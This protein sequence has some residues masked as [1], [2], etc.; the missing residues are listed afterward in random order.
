MIIEAVSSID[1]SVLAATDS[2]FN[3]EGVRQVALQ[4]VGVGLA[5]VAIIMLFG[6]SRSG[7]G[8]ALGKLA[9]AVIALVIAG[10]SIGLIS[11]RSGD[12]VGW[13]LN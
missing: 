6:I 5:V 10:L 7:I 4:I 13:L 3:V 8:D 1:M 12:I 11:G 2:P 9:I